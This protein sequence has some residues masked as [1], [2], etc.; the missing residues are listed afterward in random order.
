MK[1]LYIVAALLMASTAAHAGNSLSFEIEG[2]KI[3]IE[4]P[5]NCAE[6]SCLKISAPSLSGSSFGGFKSKR[7]D[8]DD[9]VADT[10]K[11]AP[12]PARLRL[13]HCDRA[14]AL[15]DRYPEWIARRRMRRDNVWAPRS[16]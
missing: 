14:S 5:K 4:A 10:S 1:K 6:L 3:R 13:H 7:F 15:N 12:A 11:P 8:D 2:H 16:G 9:D